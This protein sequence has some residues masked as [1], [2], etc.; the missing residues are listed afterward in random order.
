MNVL[1]HPALMLLAGALAGFLSGLRAP[2]VFGVRGALFGLCLSLTAFWVQ[3]KGW[4]LSKLLPGIVLGL[5]LF[6]MSPKSPLINDRNTLI[7][8]A[9]F[10]PVYAYCY[11]QPKFYRVVLLLLPAGAICTAIRVTSLKHLEQQNMFKPNEL[12]NIHLIQGTLLFLA[13]WLVFMWLTDPRFRKQQAKTKKDPDGNRD[14]DLR[15]S[16]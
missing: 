4:S 15:D 16:P 3:K 5:L 13:L 1:R 7:N 14:L 12:F 6:V 10:I 9:I 2:K 11:L 8:C